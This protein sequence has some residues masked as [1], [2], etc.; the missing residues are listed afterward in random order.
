MSS[1][2]A[3]KI[4]PRDRFEMAEGTSTNQ[5]VSPFLLDYNFGMLRFS[6]KRG[7]RKVTVQLIDESGAVRTELEIAEEQLRP[8]GR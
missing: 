7:E 5:W 1:N 8:N 6:G 4:I 3:V 2:L